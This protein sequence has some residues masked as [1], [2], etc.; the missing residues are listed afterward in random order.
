[1][2]RLVKRTLGAWGWPFTGWRKDGGALIL[3]FH[4]VRAGGA[5]EGEPMG[6][7]VADA[8]AFR[9]LLTWLCEVAEPIALEDWWR[10]GGHRQARKGARGFFVVTF[11]DGWADNATVAGPILRELGVPATVFLCTG[12]VEQRQPF[13]WQVAGLDDA[14]IERLKREEPAGL[15][16]RFATAGTPEVRRATA[17][18]FLTWEQVVDWAQQGGVRFGLHGH[19]HE[20][21]DSMRRADALEDVETCWRLVN[22]HVPEAARSPFFCWPNGNVRE[23]LSIEMAGLGLEGGLSTHPGI[24][25]ADWPEGRWRLPRVN[26]DARLAADCALWKWAIEKG[27]HSRT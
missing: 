10:D 5:A 11:D 12:A 4:R 23:D 24:A 17:E 20:L 19:R 26:V 9:N 25:H 13:W 8:E 14:A 1:M 3:T 21:M 15:P 2:R 7:L 6:N 16:E 22:A 27:R 18:Q